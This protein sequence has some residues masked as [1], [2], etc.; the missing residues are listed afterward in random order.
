MGDAGWIMAVEVHGGDAKDFCILNLCRKRGQ[1]L[2]HPSIFGAIRNLKKQVL[3]S[4]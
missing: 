2:S 4:C 3:T 1:T